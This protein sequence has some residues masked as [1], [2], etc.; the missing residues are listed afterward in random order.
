[1]AHY[2]RDYET[3]AEIIALIVLSI[4]LILILPFLTYWCGYF[5]GW[6]TMKTIGKE[7]IGSL[8]A[9]FGCDLA[10]KDLPKIGGA[11]GWV[12]GMFLNHN[13]SKAI[14]TNRKEK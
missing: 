11:L 4:I 5:D 3:E 12:S 2:N 10:V 9:T 14:S 6:L 8:N 13:V 1:M 7:V